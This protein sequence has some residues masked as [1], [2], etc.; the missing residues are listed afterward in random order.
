[1]VVDRDRQDLL[2]LLLT[3]HILVQALA[4]FMRCGQIGLD[5][6][7]TFLFGDGGF[8]PDDFVAQVDTFIADEDRGAGNQFLDL[9]L[10]LAA[11]RAV[12]QL[13]ASRA[14]LVRHNDYQ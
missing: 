14:F 9:M 6:Q 13:F 5:R 12:Q 3:N 11:K 1:M 10:A 7:T 4:D 2:G 8:V